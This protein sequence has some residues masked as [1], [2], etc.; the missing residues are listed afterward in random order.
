M[1]FIDIIKY[2]MYLFILSFLSFGF[3][4]IR[5][6]FQLMKIFP[7]CTSKQQAYYLSTL[8]SIIISFLSTYL[9]FHFIYSNNLTI[10][11]DWIS[12][13]TV[14]YFTSYLLCDLILGVIFY[15][16]HIGVLT[17]YVHH[18]LYIFINIYSIYTENTFIYAL[19]LISEIP[20]ILLCVGNLNKSL[21][22]NY[23]FGFVFFLFRIVYHSFLISLLYQSDTIFPMIKYLN[24]EYRSTITF[25][26][27]S[28]L[29]LHFYW[30]FK[31]MNK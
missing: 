18:T 28:I 5:L 21:R 30:F 7:Y 9:N 6:F 20:T 16:Q 1:H 17:G 25:L 15:N 27:T 19:Y 10:S 4:Q 31:W 29:G 23:L 3:L 11:L 13:L 8:N 12:I 22:T 26:A 14:S 2:K 24:I